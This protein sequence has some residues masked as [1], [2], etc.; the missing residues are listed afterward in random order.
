MRCVLSDLKL[1]DSITPP[2][3]RKVIYD[4]FFAIKRTSCDSLFTA[5]RQRFVTNIRLTP[6]YYTLR[7]FVLQGF[8]RGFLSVLVEE[9]R[10]TGLSRPFDCIIFVKNDFYDAIARL[11]LKISTMFLHIQLDHLLIGKIG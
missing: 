1:S 4:V 11:K 3:M 2:R 8:F 6:N 9:N 7:P 10:T 5:Y